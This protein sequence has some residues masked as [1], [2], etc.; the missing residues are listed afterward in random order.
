VEFCVVSFTVFAAHTDNAATLRFQN[1][2]VVSDV[3]EGFKSFVA[4]LPDERCLLILFNEARLKTTQAEFMTLIDAWFD[5]SGTQTHVAIV[6]DPIAQNAQAQLFDV[7]NVLVGGHVRSF[8]SLELA[9]E[10]LAT[11]RNCTI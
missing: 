5:A 1:D 3:I 9:Q 8:Y 6:Y 11:H 4:E 2:L 7:K 10:W